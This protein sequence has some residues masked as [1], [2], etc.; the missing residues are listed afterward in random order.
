MIG[1]RSQLD[2]TRARAQRLDLQV[3]KKA[4]NLWRQVEEMSLTGF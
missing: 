1:V 2:G 4:K 3:E